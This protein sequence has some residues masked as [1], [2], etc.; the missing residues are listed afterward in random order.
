LWE[1]G[2]L[3]KLFNQTQFELMA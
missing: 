3:I 1:E 2:L